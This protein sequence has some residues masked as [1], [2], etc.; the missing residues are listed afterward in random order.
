MPLLSISRHRD[1][2]ATPGHYAFYTVSNIMHTPG[3]TFDSRS[4]QTR[5]VVL[6]RLAQCMGPAIR[7]SRTIPPPLFIV[8]LLCTRVDAPACVQL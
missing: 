5:R 3:L 2:P 8:Y 4:L 7:F 6:A 1:H